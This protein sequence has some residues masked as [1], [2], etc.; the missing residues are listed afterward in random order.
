MKVLEGKASVVTGGGRGIGR[1]HCLRLA[2]NGGAV[3]V[4][5]VDLEEA[6]K[7]VAEIEQAG[8]KAS[9]NDSDIGTREGAAQLVDQCVSEFGRI[10]GCVNNAGIV[11][12]RTFLK[13]TDSEFDDVFR[14]HAKGTF[15]CAQEAALR[16]KEQGGGGSIVNTVSAAH[17]G[18]FGQTNY[19]GAKGAIASMTYTWALE[20]SRYGIRVNA[21]SPSGSTRMSATYKGADGKEVEAPFVD[22]T[23]NGHFVAWLCSDDANWVTGQLFGTGRDRVLV[24]EQ[25]RYG[26]GMFMP[27]GLT[28]AELQEHFRGSLGDKLESFGLMKSAYPFH[29]GVGP[30][31][32]S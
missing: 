27:G 1:G 17:Y 24:V 5:D 6:K 28:V 20:L 29:D 31:P 30:K 14:I 26:T 2:E 7:V 12:D 19:A 9:A 8:G 4:N 13:M 21:I 11:R 3:V 25:P 32:K 15:M 16:M 23:L 18:N 22:P 10:D